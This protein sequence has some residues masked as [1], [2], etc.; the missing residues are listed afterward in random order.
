M[1]LQVLSLR[2]PEA[3]SALNISKNSSVDV[4]NH[5]DFVAMMVELSQLNLAKNKLFVVVNLE[6]VKA[7]CPEQRDTVS[8]ATTPC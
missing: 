2:L 6:D 4:D 7:N 8:I 1:S 3:K 5:A